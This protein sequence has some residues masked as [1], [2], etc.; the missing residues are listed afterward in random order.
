[1][2]T[3]PGRCVYRGTGAWKLPTEGHECSVECLHEALCRGPG[4]WASAITP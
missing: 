1:M 2:G 3:G 4:H